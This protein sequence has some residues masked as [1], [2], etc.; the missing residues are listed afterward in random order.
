MNTEGDQKLGSAAHERSEESERRTDSRAAQV[1]ALA[2]RLNERNSLGGLR[3]VVREF[4][5][6]RAQQ[7]ADEAFQIE[8]AGGMLAPDG[9]RRTVGGIF[10]HLAKEAGWSGY[11]PPRSSVPR[12]SLTTAA[13]R[14]QELSEMKGRIEIMIV[15]FVARPRRALAAGKTVLLLFEVRPSQDNVPR[16]MPLPPT[17]PFEARVMIPQ[18]V[19][20]RVADEIRADRR[21]RLAVKGQAVEI[22]ELGGL[23]VWADDVKVKKPPAPSAQ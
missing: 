20:M 14:F 2:I 1:W 7:L 8:A 19:W 17:Q 5:A 15:Q 22:P 9:K 3:S 10:F 16:G 4:G 6:E 21:A 12:V 18:R 11:N 23:V 13:K